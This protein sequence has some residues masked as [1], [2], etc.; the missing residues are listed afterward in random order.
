MEKGIDS[1]LAA[2]ELVAVNFGPSNATE[3][4]IYSFD[5]PECGFTLKLIVCDWGMNPPTSI[6]GKRTGKIAALPQEGFE[7][8]SGSVAKNL[9]S[10]P[11]I[12]RYVNLSQNEV[13]YYERSHGSSCR[14]NLF[15]SIQP[16]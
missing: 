3:T 6:N 4:F 13:I 9:K 15:E 10:V 11:E 8:I 12:Y 7:Q 5:D 14:F 16:T 1:G 2:P